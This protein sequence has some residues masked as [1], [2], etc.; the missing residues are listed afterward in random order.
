MMTNEWSNVPDDPDPNG[1]LG[2]NMDELTVVRS[3]AEG[4]VV[5]LPA[6]ESSL[7]EDAFIVADADAVAELER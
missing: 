4:R 6:E 1:H 5:F 2:Y 3:K 7:Y